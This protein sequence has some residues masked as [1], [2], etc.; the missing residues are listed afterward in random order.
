[1]N[2][3]DLWDAIQTTTAVVENW[4]VLN[5]IHPGMNYNSLCF[6]G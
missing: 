2:L 4:V 3:M 1:M 6:L 5:A